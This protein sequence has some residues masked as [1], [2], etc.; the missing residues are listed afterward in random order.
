V[1]VT[2]TLGTGLV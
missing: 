2:V 1:N